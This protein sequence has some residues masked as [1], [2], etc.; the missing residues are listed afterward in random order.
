M[1]ST[2]ASSGNIAISVKATHYV[3]LARSPFYVTPDL[4]QV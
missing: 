4:D 2:S 3:E 1:V